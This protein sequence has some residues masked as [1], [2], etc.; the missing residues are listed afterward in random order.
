[1]K[2]TRK[3]KSNNPI[4]KCISHIP[5]KQ[6]LEGFRL[7]PPSLALLDSIRR[8]ITNIPIGILK[9]DNHG[10]DFHGS[11]DYMFIPEEIR[12]EIEHNHHTNKT[13]HLQ[14]SGNIHGTQI[15]V[16]FW[17]YDRE[18]NARV[19][20][21]IRKIEQWLSYA[22]QHESDGC[23]RDHLDIYLLMTAAKKRVP[24]SRNEL[25]NTEHVNTAFTYACS[26]KNRIVIFRKEDWFKTLI[27]ETFHSL[28]FDFSGHADADQYNDRVAAMFPG[29]D[30]AVDFRIYESY[31]EIWAQL[32][33]H[34]LASS[35]I[36]SFYR[37]I[38]RDGAF[39]V[40]QTQKYLNIY[41]LSYD[42]LIRDGDHDVLYQENTN[43]FSYFVVR[44]S[45]LWNLDAF[46][47]WCVEHNNDNNNNGLLAPIVF[48]KGN[49]SNYVDLIGDHFKDR[50][51][52]EFERWIE[53][54]FLKMTKKR[55][56]AKTRKQFRM[57][58]MEHVV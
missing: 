4:H 8:N 41:G 55:C 35:S 3:S 20:R 29:C 56:D 21:W 14:Y 46:L 12:G 47:K 27:H 45:L 39:M 51:F 54:R 19:G 50:G 17:T 2:R 23:R 38:R 40:Y 57:T 25:V 33:N 34:L 10:S 43:V 53:H 26:P 1:M 37:N 13:Q 6:Y 31:C 9:L 48:A 18:D 36:E 42:D 11:A 52:L 24:D 44:A 58:M 7:S 28:G 49:V 5:P 22:L 16:H 32:F 15:N 30:P